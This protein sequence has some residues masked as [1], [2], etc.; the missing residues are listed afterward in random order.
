MPACKV[1]NE[2][3]S[4]QIHTHMHTHKYTLSTIG[5]GTFRN[6]TVFTG[7]QAPCSARVHY[8]CPR[9]KQ[10][11]DMRTDSQ[12]SAV[13]HNAYVVCVCV[14]VCVCMVWLSVWVSVWVPVWVCLGCDCVWVCVVCV[15]LSISLSVCYKHT[16]RQICTHSIF[17][18]VLCTFR[19]WTI[20]TGVQ[21]PCSAA[22]Q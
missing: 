5:L 3:T 4:E 8:P 22:P 9:V 12:I 1:S 14:C 17:D 13:L 19:S 6:W 7:G 21:A 10:R 15:F 20:F 11:S 16:H 18:I 2:A